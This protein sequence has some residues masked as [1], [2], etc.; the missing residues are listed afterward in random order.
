MAL[1]STFLV[2]SSL[3][4]AR[5]AVHGRQGTG[6]RVSTAPAVPGPGTTSVWLEPS[7]HERIARQ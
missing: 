1:T 4:K 7:A 5:R 6:L 3:P 2:A